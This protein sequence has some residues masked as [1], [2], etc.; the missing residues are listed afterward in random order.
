MIPWH[1][2]CPMRR[3]GQEVKLGLSMFKKQKER[4][5]QSKR[6]RKILKTGREYKQ[7]Q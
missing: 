2:E 6:L 5:K 1:R 7:E 4:E 3:C